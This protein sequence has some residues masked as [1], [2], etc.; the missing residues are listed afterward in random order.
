MKRKTRYAVSGAL[1]EGISD[2]LADAQTL[3]ITHEL[4]REVLRADDENAERKAL[5]RMARAWL[6]RRGEI[7][8][9]MN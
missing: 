3:K 8:L 6:A 1:A 5:L 4:A 7:A 9:A 2:A